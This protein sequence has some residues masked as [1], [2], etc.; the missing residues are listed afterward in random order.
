LVIADDHLG[1]FLT[2]PSRVTEG[3]RE[4]KN[5]GNERKREND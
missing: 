2:F 1:A 4:K 5:K 3:R